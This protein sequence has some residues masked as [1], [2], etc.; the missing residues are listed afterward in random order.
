MRSTRS[1]C[2]ISIIPVLLAAAPPATSS[3]GSESGGTEGPF[4]FGAGARALALGGAYVALAEGPT[5]LVW[6][7]AGLAGATRKEAT[8]FYTSPFVEGNRYSYLAYIHPFLDIGTLGFAGNRYGVDDIPKYGMDGAAL[9]HFSNIQNEWIFSYALPPVGPISMGASLKAETHSLDGYAATGIGADLGF[10]LRLRDLE[11]TFLSRRDITLGL[12]LRNALEPKLTLVNEED[13]YPFLLRLGF[14]YRIAFREGAA[15]ELL[16][17]AALDQGRESGGRGRGG[18]EYLL[19]N[20]LALRAG[21]GGGE[22]SAGTGIE[23]GFGSLDYAFASRE[24]GSS[25]RF[26]LTLAFGREI[27]ELREDRRIREE[28]LLE[29]RTQAKLERKEQNQIAS[30]MQ[31]ADDLFRAGKHAEAEVWYERVLI[32]DPENDEAQASLERTRI[33]K[34]LKAGDRHRAEGELFEA[35]AQYRAALVVAPD[36]ERVSVRL[37]ETTD[38]V[39]RTEARNRE[40]SDRITRGIEY[41]ALSDLS[42][43]RTE[44]ADALAIE[45]D[46]ADA[47]RYRVKTDSLVTL[48]IDRLVE[49]GN[50]F[51]DRERPETAIERY[52]E[53]LEL[54][55]DRDDL[56]R[57]IARL[58]YSPETASGEGEAETAGTAPD[59]VVVREISPDERRE[60]DRMYRS[61]MDA[62]RDGRNDEAIRYFEFVYGL[63]PSFENVESYLAQA[64]L[65]LGMDHYTDGNLDRAIQAWERIL[66]ID[67]ENE[68]ALSYVRRARV[69]IR[70]AEDL[71]GG[72][73]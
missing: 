44:F 2:L 52:R 57:E 6:N 65:F 30:D 50:W 34:H 14:A 33:E 37:H 72:S 21:A 10:L 28:N 66:E 38:M 59:P 3:G 54:R 43:A 19:T 13:R 11:N 62:F 45:P 31:R 49:E 7:P 47:Q 73:P 12:A 9:G 24:M 46:N 53:V 40:V 51:R 48:R 58:E 70:K 26:G 1:L 61:G 27:D 5:A 8:F 22:W 32:W 71:S 64:H 4:A 35:I 16:L 18:V 23:I 55:P 63:M 60:T 39:N 67:P 42:N 68:K 25:H 15:G 17:L 56:V 69:E 20:G 41:L 29:E 36:E